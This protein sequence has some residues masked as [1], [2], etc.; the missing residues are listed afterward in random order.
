MYG[1]PAV[2]ASDIIHLMAGSQR[3]RRV[4]QHLECYKNIRTYP[5]VRMW[6]KVGMY[7]VIERTK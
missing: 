4:Q 2:H 1:S 7:T 6:P 5:L 3:L